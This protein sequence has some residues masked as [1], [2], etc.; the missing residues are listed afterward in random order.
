M[1][2]SPQCT[3]GVPFCFGSDI[4]H[5]MSLNI[6]DLL[7]PLWCGTFE[8]DKKDNRSTWGWAVLK[9]DVWIEH[10]KAVAATH[11]HLPGSFDCPPQ[12]PAEKISSGYKAWE[13]TIYVYGLG[14]ALLFGILPDLLAQLLQAS[15]WCSPCQS[16]SYFMGQ[17]ADYLCPSYRVQR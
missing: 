14:P 12:N 6:P 11:H 3:L 17:G 4:M 1:G 15:S 9:D 13:Y 2:F 10:G 7:I 5:L 8:C 16:A